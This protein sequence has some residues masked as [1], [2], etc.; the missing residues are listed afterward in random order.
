MIWRQAVVARQ[1]LRWEL[2]ALLPIGGVFLTA[3]RSGALVLLLAALLVWLFARCQS[4]ALFMLGRTLFVG[5]MLSVVIL[6]IT[7]NPTE[8]GVVSHVQTALSDSAPSIRVMVWTICL[9]LW[10]DHLWLGVGW[11][12]LAAHLMDSAAPVIAAHPE[13]TPIASQLAGGVTRTHNLVL[14][15]LV[16]GGVIAGSALL[17]LFVALANRARRWWQQPPAPTSAAASGWICAVIM[18]AH[19][20]VSVAI[21]E[22]FF[23]VLLAISLAVCFANHD[24]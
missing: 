10:L 20:M 3:S 8:S 14:Q 11:G 1:H 13:F 5:A 18:L 16:E 23:M 19:G 2:A 17:L 22:P 4:R 7:P 9:S 6:A 24:G 15:F 12:N 21:M